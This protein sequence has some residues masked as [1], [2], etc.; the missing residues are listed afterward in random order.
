[1]Y[2][3]IYVQY[4]IYFYYFIYIFYEFFFSFETWLTVWIALAVLRFTVITYTC[5]VFIVYDFTFCWKKNLPSNFLFSFLRYINYFPLRF[6]YIHT[7]YNVI[8]LLIPFNNIKPI[9]ICV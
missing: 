5:F 1:M 9:L 6:T 2:T 7:S 3:H 4:Y 8:Y